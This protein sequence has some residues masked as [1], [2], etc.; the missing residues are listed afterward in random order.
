MLSNRSGSTYNLSSTTGWN[1]YGYMGNIGPKNRCV[2]IVRL[3]RSSP[4][5][6]DQILYQLGWS[7]H[8]VYGRSGESRRRENTVEYSEANIFPRVRIPHI[9]H[10]ML[11]LHLLSKIS[12]S[13]FHSHYRCSSA[14]CMSLGDG[15][16]TSSHYSRRLLKWFVKKAGPK[17]HS[18]RCGSLTVS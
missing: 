1:R 13:S 18:Q 16:S 8:L 5:T 2:H 15:Q 10:G 12:R 6:N 17:L 7:P 3:E 9:L 11:S 14:P 4:L